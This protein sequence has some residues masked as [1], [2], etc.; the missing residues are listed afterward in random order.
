[1][2][3]CRYPVKQLFIISALSDAARDPRVYVACPTGAQQLAEH[4]RQATSQRTAG[5]PAA[6]G[7]EEQTQTAQRSTASHPGR[8]RRR[9][10]A[11]RS[12]T[13]S[14][15]TGRQAWACNAESGNKIH[16]TRAERRTASGPKYEKSAAK[17]E[18]ST[19][20]MAA[21]MIR[22]TVR[23]RPSSS[24]GDADPPAPAADS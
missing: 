14:C 18:P 7:P 8:R 9:E 1:M 4:H 10:P 19:A 24:P 21:C 23:G 6:L 11:S 12:K 17:T 13:A 20:L 5:D 16:L 15:R 2:W 3:R 22:G